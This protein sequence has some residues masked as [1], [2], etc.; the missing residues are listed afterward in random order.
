MAMIPPKK[1]TA[2][3]FELCP[4]GP[5]RLICVDIIDWGVVSS[6]FSGKERMQHKISLRWQS[7]HHMKTGKKLPYL[8]Q[9]RY[10]FSMHEKASLRLDVNGWRGTPLTDE[11]AAV[12]DLEKLLGRTCFANI[13]HVKKP[14]GTFAEVVALMPLPRGMAK[15]TVE[16]YTRMTERK[17]GEVH[18]DHGQGEAYEGP[19]SANADTSFDEPQGPEPP[20]F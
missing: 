18:D 17:P 6:P 4:A 5:Q 16:G 20:E 3:N 19:E 7:E 8:V 11:E 15:L 13:A 2:A 1:A 9:K 10:T 14:R 12:F